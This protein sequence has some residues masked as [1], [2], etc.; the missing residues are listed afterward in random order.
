MRIFFLLITLLGLQ[1][2]FAD[3]PR[4]RYSFK[5]SNLRFELKP[6][7][8]IFSDNKVYTDSTYNNTTKEYFISSYTLP[9]RYYWGLYDVKTKQKLYTIKNDGLFIE[10]KTALISDDGQNIVIIDD[11]SWGFGFKNLEMMTFYEKENRIKR[12]KLGDLIEN[13]CSLTYSVSHMKWCS[14]FYFNERNEIVVKTNEFYNY[15]YSKKGELISKKRD[16]IIKDNDVIIS[17]SIKRLKRNRYEI[18][19]IYCIIGNLNSKTLSDLECKDQIMKKIYGKV[20]GF[21]KSKNKAMKEVFYRTLLIRDSKVQNIDFA[22][23]TYNS[24]NNCQYYNSID[25]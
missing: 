14:N 22:K 11:Y 16:E 13:I 4:L 24:S 7:D 8:T 23:P 12:L 9:D 2:I 17:A 3:Q 1:K 10:T 5:S 6:C 25:I 20:Y 15:T 18:N 19:L 21:L